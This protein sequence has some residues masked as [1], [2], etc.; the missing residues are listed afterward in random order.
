MTRF[1]AVL[2]GRDADRRD[3]L[4]IAACPSTSSGL[5]GSSIH[6]RL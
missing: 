5:V 4:A 3:A 1:A 6:H 2:A